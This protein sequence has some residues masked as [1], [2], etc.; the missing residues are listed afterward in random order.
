MRKGFQRNGCFAFNRG[1]NTKGCSTPECVKGVPH[2]SMLTSAVAARCSIEHRVISA[3]PY[4]VAQK[5]AGLPITGLKAL[6]P[7]I[8]GLRADRW[9]RMVMTLT[10]DHSIISSAPPYSNMAF[11]TNYIVRG[12]VMSTRCATERSIRDGATTSRRETYENKQ[13]RSE[14]R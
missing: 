14:E 8:E 11:P 6:G 7:E 2:D 5:Y 13:V 9:V 4:K 1:C 12:L 3:Y 10:R